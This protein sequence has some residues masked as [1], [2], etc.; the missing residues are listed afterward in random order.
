MDAQ[1]LRDLTLYAPFERGEA[2][3]NVQKLIS[4]Q[5]AWSL[6][7]EAAAK[8]WI[9]EMEDVMRKAYRVELLYKPREKAWLV[10]VWRVWG[11]DGEWPVSVDVSA[12]D[13]RIL[14]AP[15]M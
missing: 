1:G 6:A 14:Q 8:G 7:V 11:M 10:P 2:E 3:G 9:E 4:P 12:E 15:W 13:G 5:Q